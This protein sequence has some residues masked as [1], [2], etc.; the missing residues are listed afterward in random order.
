MS[1]KTLGTCARQ[2]V[3]EMAGI[4]SMDVLIPV[5]RGQVETRLRVRVVSTPEPPLAQLLG[6]LGLRLPKTARILTNVV[7]KNTP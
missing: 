1:S 4:K 5:K 2:L 7:P 6:H 3:K